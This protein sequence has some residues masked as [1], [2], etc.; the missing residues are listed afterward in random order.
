VPLA[1]NGNWCTLARAATHGQQGVASA[2]FIALTSVTLVLFLALMQGVELV[3]QRQQLNRL[4]ETTAVA[5]SDARRGLLAQIPCELAEFLA[6]SNGVRLQ[7]CRIVNDGV[8]IA[9]AKQHLLVD[10]ES[11]AYAGAP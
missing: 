1:T 3:Y 8:I 5:A 6:L 2:A 7:S 9:L 4:A 11:V 10:F